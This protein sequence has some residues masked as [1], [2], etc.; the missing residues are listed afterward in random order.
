M[1]RRDQ[2]PETLAAFDTVIDELAVH[3]GIERALWFGAHAA[4]VEGKIFL[5]IFGGTLVARVGAEE[6][7][8]RVLSGHGERFDPSGKGRAMRDWLQ[9]S[10]EPADWP[11]LA[12]AALAFSAPR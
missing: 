2:G 1:A 11:E 9:T 12:Q 5:A 6:V 3:A 7:D 4:K 10:L 8:D